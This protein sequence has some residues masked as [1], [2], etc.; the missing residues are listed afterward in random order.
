M[1]RQVGQILQTPKGIERTSKPN[2]QKP[3][4]R[5]TRSRVLLSCVSAC[6]I[7]WERLAH[8]GTCWTSRDPHHVHTTLTLSHPSLEHLQELRQPQLPP[9][10][11]EST[12]ERPVSLRTRL[13]TEAGDAGLAEANP[14][15]LASRKGGLGC[16]AAD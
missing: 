2:P 11:T 4:R 3:K 9:S 8:L 10:Q 5:V 6:G 1:K 7:E 13:G 14:P 12:G 16:G 15:F